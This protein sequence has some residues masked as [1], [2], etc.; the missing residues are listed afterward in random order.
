M[1]K[2]TSKLKKNGSCGQEILRHQ[3]ATCSSNERILYISLLRSRSCCP[4]PSPLLSSSTC[5]PLPSSV[6]NPGLIKPPPLARCVCSWLQEFDNRWSFITVHKV[7]A[8]MR[9]TPPPYPPRGKV[10]NKLLVKPRTFICIFA[11]QLSSGRTAYFSSSMSCGAVM[12]EMTKKTYRNVTDN[13]VVCRGCTYVFFSDCTAATQ[14]ATPP[15]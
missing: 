13:T 11:P 3:N 1:K 5:A 2:K 6:P 14:S 8:V 7:I 12:G 15:A 10:K 4:P 9:N